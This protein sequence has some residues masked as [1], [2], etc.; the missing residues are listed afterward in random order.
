MLLREGGGGAGQT[1]IAEGSRTVG[2]F[3]ARAGKKMGNSGRR[4]GGRTHSLRRCSSMHL[5]QKRCRHGDTTFTFFRVP[6]HTAHRVSWRTTSS[7]I[8]ARARITDFCGGFPPQQNGEVLAAVGRTIRTRTPVGHA[9]S[10][11]DS[12]VREPRLSIFLSTRILTRQAS[13][14]SQ[15]SRGAIPSKSNPIQP[16]RRRRSLVSIR[17]SRR[18]VSPSL[19][20]SSVANPSPSDPLHPR[21][22]TPP[23]PRLSVWWETAVPWSRRASG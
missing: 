1:A 22:P 21:A 19:L 7:F 14:L 17:T 10:R 16:R 9:S 12:R 2:A 5:V 13:G 8:G 18:R 20:L 15:A 6:Q 4:R 23:P 3:G 11:G